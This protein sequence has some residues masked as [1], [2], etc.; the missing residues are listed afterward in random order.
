[1]HTLLFSSYLIPAV[2]VLSTTFTAV[3]PSL[4]II[5]DGSILF[6][7]SPNANGNYPRA[8]LAMYSCDLNFRLTGMANRM[9]E[10]DKQWSGM[11]PTCERE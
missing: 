7:S 2:I 9:C 5:E 3:C 4:D 1:M 6:S 8:T 11:A 10:M